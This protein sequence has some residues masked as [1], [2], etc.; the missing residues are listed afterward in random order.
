MS[1]PIHFMRNLQMAPQDACLPTRFTPVQQAQYP[2]ATPARF[3]KMVAPLTTKQNMNMQTAVKQQG[4]VRGPKMHPAS[5][6]PPVTIVLKNIP[7][8]C[9]ATDVLAMIEDSGFQGKFEFLYMPMKP[10]G[11]KNKGYVFISFTDARTAEVL[12]M[13]MRG[14]RFRQR[15]S[16]K[17]VVVEIARKNV[18]LTQVQRAKAVHAQ[19]SPWGPV[20]VANSEGYETLQVQ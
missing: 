6:A 8:R 12:Q 9:K 19:E 7:S 18:P 2:A 5:G 15:N 10:E 13:A 16:Q 4:V 3:P 17:T 14:S 11:V 20:L 1:D